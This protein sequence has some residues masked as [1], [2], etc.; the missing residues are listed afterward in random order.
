MAFPSG[1]T[2]SSSTC[3]QRYGAVRHLG[4][5]HQNGLFAQ[6]GVNDRSPIPL[7]SSLGFVFRVPIPSLQMQLSKFLLKIAMEWDFVHFFNCGRM[8]RAV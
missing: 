7:P 4:S 8:M 3:G 2:Y 1:S 6:C 5:G